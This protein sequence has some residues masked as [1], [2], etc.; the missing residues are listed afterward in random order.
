MCGNLQDRGIE[1]II[2]ARGS[3]ITTDVLGRITASEVHVVQ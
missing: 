2:A 3:E 1:W